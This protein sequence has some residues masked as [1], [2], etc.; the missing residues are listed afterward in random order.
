MGF[1]HSHLIY[2]FSWILLWLK[3]DKSRH[4]F[5]S[6]D[7]NGWLIYWFIVETNGKLLLLFFSFLNLGKK[8]ERSLLLASE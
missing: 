2:R 1:V 7:L 6:S 4:V 5:G 8:F 3:M